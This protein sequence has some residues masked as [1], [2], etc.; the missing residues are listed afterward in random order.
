MTVEVPVGLLVASVALNIFC[1]VIIAI[2]V[3]GLNTVLKCEDCRQEE[4]DV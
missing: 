2:G 4:R 1:C 3:I